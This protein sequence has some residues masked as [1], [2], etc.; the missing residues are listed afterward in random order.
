MYCKFKLVTQMK[1]FCKKFRV[2][3]LKCDVVF[4]HSIL[5]LDIVTQEF[6]TSEKT[7]V[8]TIFTEQLLF[9]YNTLNV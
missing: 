2:T 3:F 7:E 8:I 6:Q 5:Q 1:S 4:H 9:Y